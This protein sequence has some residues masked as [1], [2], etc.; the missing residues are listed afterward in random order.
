MSTIQNKD[1]FRF[2]SM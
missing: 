1:W 2:L